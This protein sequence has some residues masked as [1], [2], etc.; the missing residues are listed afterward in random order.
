MN[1]GKHSL[2]GSAP[3]FRMW[4]R[5]YRTGKIVRRPNGRPFCFYKKR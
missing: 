3:V 5:H 1:H 2:K 4:F